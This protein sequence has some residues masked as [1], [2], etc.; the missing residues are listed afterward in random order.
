MG[1][2][3]TCRKR[4]HEQRERSVSWTRY[5]QQNVSI[6]TE[7]QQQDYGRGNCFQMPLHTSQDHSKRPALTGSV[8][9]SIGVNA[10]LQKGLTCQSH[11]L[12]AENEL[13]L[14]T[15]DIHSSYQGERWPLFHLFLSLSLFL[16][17]S[18]FNR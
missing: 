10:S 16:S 14:Y 8:S 11:F 15:D 2:R 3:R 18:L 1:Y 12:T 4:V 17:R 7:H 6:K 5:P 13:L 9:W